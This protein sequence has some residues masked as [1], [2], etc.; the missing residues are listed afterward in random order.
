[1]DDPRSL[2]L[3]ALALADALAGE[4]TDADLGRSTPCA[5]WDLAALLAHVAG[6]YHGFARALET[7][8]A[9]VEA[10]APVAFSAESWSRCLGEL[11]AALDD[12]DLDGTARI[13]ELAPMPL[14]VRYVLRAQLLDTVVHS[15]DIARALDRVWEPPHRLVAEVAAIAESIPATASG[16]GRAF[17]VPLS[18]AG[19]V[20]ER[21]LA[22]VGRDPGWTR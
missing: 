1:M 17:A 7:G 22:R 2:L 9:P 15:W 18:R 16:P 8:D 10:L 5:G 19:T 11:R 6:Q 21:T 3:D 4:V 13:V 12:V 14:P 20:W